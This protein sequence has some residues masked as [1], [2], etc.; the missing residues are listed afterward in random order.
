MR[1]TI[2]NS[3][4]LVTTSRPRGS[5]YPD[6]LLSRAIQLLGAGPAHATSSVAR[7]AANLLAAAGA[8]LLVWSSVIHLQLWSDGYRSISVIGPLFLIQGVS[9]ILLAVILVVFRRL[10]LMAAGAGLL[11]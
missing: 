7:W 6:S 2:M 3:E 4:H 5:S 10:V 9:G 1:R 8:G 11:A